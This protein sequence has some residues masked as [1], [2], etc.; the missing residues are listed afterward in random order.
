MLPKLKDIKINTLKELSL[1][2]GIE[3]TVL[4]NV[5]KYINLHYEKF[6]KRIGKKERMLYKADHSLE[7]ILKRIERRLLDRF[8][9]PPS[10]QGGIKGRSPFTNAKPHA[11]KMNVGH[12]DIK[13]FFPSVRPRQVY[14]AF[15]KLGCSPDV[16]HLLTRLVTADGH[17]PQGF[18][19][20]TKIAAFVLLNA[21]KRLSI[22]LEKYGAKHTIWV[23]DITISGKYPIKK[24][25]S[26]IRKILKQEGFESHK[27]EVTYLNQRQ[28][29]TGV[30]VNTKPSIRK[31][32]R[33]EVKKIIFKCR[34]FGIKNYLISI[35]QKPDITSFVRKINGSLSN[36]I[37]IDDKKYRP[38]YQEWQ[39]IVSNNH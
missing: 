23:D 33:E 30:V 11:K 27:E 35:K 2:L 39:K 28:V 31:E 8:D 19:T 6:P 25:S 36:M 4:Q 16:A 22:F 38:L 7:E 13:N 21:D 10:I 26:G 20:S 17:L 5:V 1:R 14:N 37:A 24:L 12:F 34:K 29:V 3:L 9:F 15:N 32:K 18:E